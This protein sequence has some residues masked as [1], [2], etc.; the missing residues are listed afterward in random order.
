MTPK[1]KPCPLLTSSTRSPSDLQRRRRASLGPMT[2]MR[3][4]LRTAFLALVACA[5]K[6]LVGM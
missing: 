4:N 3:Q 1:A 5:D 6:D 2:L